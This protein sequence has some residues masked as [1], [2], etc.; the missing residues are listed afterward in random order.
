MPIDYRFH[1]R[2]V[3]ITLSLAVLQRLSRRYLAIME[4][5][6][7]LHFR[8]ISAR[9]RVPAS[10]RV[11]SARET[12]EQRVTTRN[13]QRTASSPAAALDEVIGHH[14]KNFDTLHEAVRGML[15]C[16]HAV[17]GRQYESIADAQRRFAALLQH[18]TVPGD[19]DGATTAGL[20]FARVALDAGL[21]QAEMAAKAQLDALILWSRYVSDGVADLRRLAS[22]GTAGTADD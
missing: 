7:P 12:R 15:D 14:R 4:S 2:K 1:E 5:I 13:Q 18:P 19:L 20:D 11:S 6:L 22:N 3:S 9:E 16:A 17:A 21:A 10:R 8:R